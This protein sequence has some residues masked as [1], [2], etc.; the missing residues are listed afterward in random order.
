MVNKTS[1]VKKK[2][3]KWPVKKVVVKKD[4]VVEKPTTL[5]KGKPYTVES[6]KDAK[7]LAVKV[8]RVALA[9]KS[10]KGRYGAHTFRDE[11]VIVTKITDYGDYMYV[12][13]FSPNLNEE[14][15]FYCAKDFSVQKLTKAASKDILSKFEKYQFRN[16]ELY[17]GFTVGSDPE[18]FVENKAGEMI[19]AF[20]FL[21]S[22]E[23]PSKTAP[24]LRSGNERLGSLPMY[25]DGFQ[26][27]FTTAAETCLGWHVDS[28]Q[29]GLQGVLNEARKYN[30]EA[31]LSLKTVM[32]LSPSQL[33]DSKEEHVSF[34]CMPSYNAYDM[35]GLSL[36]GREV[37][38]R[39][40]GGHIHYGIGKIGD[41]YKKEDIINGVKALDAI[42]GVA[43]VSFFGKIDDPRRRKMYG[44]AGEYRLPPHGLEYRVLSNAWLCHP[45]VMNII[46]DVSR[47]ALMFGLNGYMKYWKATEQETIECINNCDVVKAREIME[48]NKELLQLIISK[49]YGAAGAE[50]VYNAFMSGVESI[51]VNPSDIDGN[52][53]LSGT[54]ITHSD[55]VGKNFNKAFYVL[56]DNKKV[57]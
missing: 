26:A 8:P 53:N 16:L 41:R 12:K 34:G 28:V 46:F 18:I 6:I 55:G 52:W 57:S 13:Y 15:G 23:A 43:C 37:P 38:F 49:Q 20:E 54:W 21:G 45:L 39:P 29:L 4:K 36:P 51:V 31:K 30:P 10:G 1:T 42:L 14:Y 32:E 35:K 48:R 3:T 17:H 7:N 5:L 40:A 22:K 50:T 27:E 9:D 33:R 24:S 56:K 11:N 2:A 47:K 19:P 25:W 44:L